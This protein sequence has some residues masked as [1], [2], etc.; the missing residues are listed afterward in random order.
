[1][2]KIK[3]FFQKENLKRWWPWGAG[4]LAVILAAVVLVLILGGSGPDDAPAPTGTGQPSTTGE[5]TAPSDDAADG[6]TA[7]PTD[8][9]GEPSGSAVIRNPLT[10]A[11]LEEPLLSRPI[12]VML[13]NIKAA[14][15]QHG[16][17]QADILYE[18]LAEGGIT[19]C[20]GI[21]SD[22]SQVEK[23]GSIRSARKYYVDL[24]LGYGAAYV[25]AGSSSDAKAFLKELEDMDLDA[26]LSAKY[27]YRDQDRLNAGYSLEHTL[28]SSGENVLAF[29][30]TRKVSTTVQE[31]RSYGMI[32]SEEANLSGQAA[33]KITVYFHM[34][35]SPSG[36]TKTTVLTYNAGDR[37]YYAAQHGGDYIDGNTNETVS[38]R[39]VLVLR[40]ETS[41][42]SDGKKLNVE[43]TGSGDGQ[44]FCNGQTVA[45]RWSRGSLE[46]PFSFT[47]E[48]GEPVT[49]A[50][51]STYIAVVPTGAALAF[52]QIG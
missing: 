50:V 35:G 12:A 25:H 37:L 26:G 33:D 20:M 36:S 52:E 1:M 15:P 51:G 24:A 22:I 23:L 48:N 10:G 29:A 32:F 47:L 13:N 11:V 31:E 27:F 42:Q 2:D 45:I 16:V 8:G 49:F 40:A 5:T 14:M 18:V 39:N 44:F 21:Y 9:T 38:F 19:R 6:T 43:T 30:G 34:S 46:E 4:A 3:A 28:F 17:S 7:D 41:L